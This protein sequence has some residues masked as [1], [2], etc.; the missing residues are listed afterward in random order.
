LLSNKNKP[1][2]EPKEIL[3][4]LEKKDMSRL[5]SEVITAYLTGYDI[6]KILGPRIKKESTK[7]KSIMHNLVGM[8]IVQQTSSSLTARELLDIEK[9]SIKNITRRIDYLIRGM[10]DDL[11]TCKSKDD[12]LHIYDR[13]FDVNRLSYLIFRT[14]KKAYDHPYIRQELN[15]SYDELNE[16]RSVIFSMETVGDYVK[17]L[18]KIYCLR[19]ISDSKAFYDIGKSFQKKYHDVMETFYKDEKE[20]AYE[21]EA[22]NEDR[23]ALCKKFLHENPKYY[24]AELSYLLQNISRAIRDIARNVCLRN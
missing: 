9:T 20:K 10:F 1:E 4:E 15:M 8:E 3:I 12:W 14:I 22:E 19:K 23:I 7:I 6:I 5:N 21:L 16:Y 2:E 11:F 24:N 18:A 13:D 17:R